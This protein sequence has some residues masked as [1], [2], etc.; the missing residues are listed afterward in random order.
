MNDINAKNHLKCEN[1]FNT[2]IL[3]FMTPT[4]MLKEAHS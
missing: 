3:L 2:E 1:I 4:N